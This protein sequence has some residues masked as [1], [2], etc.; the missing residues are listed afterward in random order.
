VTLYE[1]FK[2]LLIRFVFVQ[3]PHGADAGNQLFGFLRTNGRI[4][5]GVFMIRSGRALRGQRQSIRLTATAVS[6]L[7][8]QG[9]GPA[10]TIVNV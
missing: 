1:D 10:E 6:S 8:H 3:L 4:P 2:C 9:Y 7:P 5:V